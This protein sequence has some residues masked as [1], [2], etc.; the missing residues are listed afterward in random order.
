MVASLCDMGEV[1][2]A[3]A[4][5]IAAAAVAV[6]AQ[7]VTIWGRMVVSIFFAFVL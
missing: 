2:F 5:Y 4:R 1:R 7:A 6:A 3:V